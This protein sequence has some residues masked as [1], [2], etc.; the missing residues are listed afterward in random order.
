MHKSQYRNTSNMK[1]QV[2]S[3]ESLNDGMDEMEIEYESLK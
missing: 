3:V 1:K 2:S